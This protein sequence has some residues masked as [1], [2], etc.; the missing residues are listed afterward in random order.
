MGSNSCIPAGSRVLLASQPRL[1]ARTSMRAPSPSK[2][3]DWGSDRG[4][5]LQAAKP[6]HSLIAVS[7]S[8]LHDDP[9]RAATRSADTARCAPQC[10]LTRDRFFGLA[11]EVR[12]A[13]LAFDGL[14]EGSS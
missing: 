12:P 2:R 8:W 5:S 9:C 1:S 4:R 3:A 7:S 11:N 6:M 14:A 10:V 13:G